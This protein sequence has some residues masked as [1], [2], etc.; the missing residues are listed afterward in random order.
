MIYPVN[1]IAII[2][3]A[4]KTIYHRGKAL[5]FGWASS[6]H[7]WILAVDDGIIYKIEKQKNG[8]N[9]IY[10]K[11]N[12]GMISAYGHLEGIIVKKGQ[13]VV[14]GEHIA[15]M[16]AS[17]TCTAEHLHFELH[18]KGSN[19]YGKA[20]L[21]PMKYLQVGQNQKVLNST[22]NKKYKNKF[23]YAPENEKF[24]IARTYRLL[25]EKA[26][27]TSPS[28]INNEMKV[29]DV[30]KNLK[31][32][33]TSKKPN[34]KAIFKLGTDVFV[35]EIKEEKNSRI[36][37]K[38]ENCYIVLRNQDGTEQCEKLKGI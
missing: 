14:K 33:L 22:T 28:L 26:L 2:Q 25:V 38:V 7:Q 5:D 18:S 21:D 8:G 19:M 17:G 23:L 11:H 37:G 20:D 6:H 32:D 24:E 35:T 10:L 3:Q 13:K 36:W 30:K 12:T 29:K 9:V 15:R 16:G 34:D 4:S 31:K 1:N 27:R